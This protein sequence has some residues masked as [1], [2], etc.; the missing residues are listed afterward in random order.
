[1]MEEQT[2]LPPSG[3]SLYYNDWVLVSTIR[4]YTF[5]CAVFL[6]SQVN[7]INQFIFEIGTCCD[8]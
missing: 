6:V 5:L 7:S 1:M 8:F 2:L 4:I 3:K